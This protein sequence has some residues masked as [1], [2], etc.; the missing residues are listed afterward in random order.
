MATRVV[1]PGVTVRLSGRLSKSRHSGLNVFKFGSSLLAGFG[2]RWS[3]VESRKL[4]ASSVPNTK[5]ASCWKVTP[6]QPNISPPFAGAN[7]LQNG[8]ASIG[9]WCG[10]VSLVPWP[11]TS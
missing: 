3:G 6:G 8:T 9:P 4:V 1:L 5:F 7:G 2:Y 11:C 10:S